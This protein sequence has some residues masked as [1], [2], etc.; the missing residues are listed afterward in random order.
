MMEISVSTWLG[1]A[2]VA[3]FAYLL[4]LVIALFVVGLIRLIYR[5]IH[6]KGRAPGP[7]KEERKVEEILT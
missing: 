1:G 5:L 3:L 2:G 6:R 7:P 4:T